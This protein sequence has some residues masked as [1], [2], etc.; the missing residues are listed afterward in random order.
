[1][2]SSDSPSHADAVE[3]AIKEARQVLAQAQQLREQSGLSAAQARDALESRLSDKDLEE[4]R[5]A[6]QADLDQ[7]SRDVLQHSLSGKQSLGQ[8]VA[9]KNRPII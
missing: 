9:R 4:V 5:A 1:M 7:V 8:G 2:L 3:R 6:V